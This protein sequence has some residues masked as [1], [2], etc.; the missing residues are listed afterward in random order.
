MTGPELTRVPTAVGDLRAGIW[1]PEGGANVPG[2]VV[3][4]GSGDGAFDD[5]GD[6][7]AW[8]A[9][10]GA[11]VLVHDKPGCGG[12]PGDWTAQTLDDRAAETL[13]AV[14][15]LR[16]HPAVAGRPIGLLGISQGG[17]V[18]L[19]A[20]VEGGADRSVDFVV[21]L[22]GP[23]VGPAE[24]ERVRIERE[25]RG[26][27]VSAAD[28]AE[29]LA[30]V[31]E[32]TRR[33]IGGEPVTDVIAYQSRYADRPW[34]TIATRYFDDPR[35]MRFLAGILAFDPVEYMPDVSCPVLALFGAEDPLVPVPESVAAFATHLRRLD[36]LAVFPGADH[37][38]FTG[39]PDPTRSR[40]DQLAPGFVPMFTEFLAKR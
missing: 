28:L 17:W 32:R 4:D 19:R 30:W 23:G 37:G 16:R 2:L 34:F 38:L 35:T 25:L 6:W 8:L 10:C 40:S 3:V 1:I 9:S 20:A 24:Q 27:R 31:D 29:A 5:F 12:S 13:A 11:A 14:S 18:S 36:G 26:D 22:S 7:P 39:P 33:L 15:V 21:T